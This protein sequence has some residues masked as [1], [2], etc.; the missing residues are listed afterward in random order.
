MRVEKHHLDTAWR[1]MYEGLKAHYEQERPMREALSLLPIDG[2]SLAQLARFMQEPMGKGIANDDALLDAMHRLEM[3]IQCPAFR[4]CP[5]SECDG[6]VFCKA[7]SGG[8]GESH[9]SRV[10]R[11][12]PTREEHKA[13][14]LEYFKRRGLLLS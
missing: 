6:G 1:W 8:Q 9:G 14:I 5:L 10:R 7:Y 4:E 3:Q 2:P 13:W 12:H 11:E